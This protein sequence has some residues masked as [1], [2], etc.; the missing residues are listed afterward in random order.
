[1]LALALTASGCYSADGD[2]PAAVNGRQTMSAFDGTSFI[3]PVWE[4]D[5]CFDNA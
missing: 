5:G 2:G 1:M 4:F 3:N